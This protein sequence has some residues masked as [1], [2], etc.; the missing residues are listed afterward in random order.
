MICSKSGTPA[1]AT[2]LHSVPMRLKTTRHYPPHSMVPVKYPYFEDKFLE[3]TEVSTRMMWVM[4]NF[5]LFKLDD[6]E[7]ERNFDEMGLD[8][9]EQTA[10]LTSIEHEFHT[11]FED[12]VF[13]N[14]SNFSQVRE[15]IATDHMAF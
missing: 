13:E 11:V 1:R 10:I 6:L 9:L 2:S 14:F 7:W 5:N 3:E 8:S 12:R 4:H 15:F